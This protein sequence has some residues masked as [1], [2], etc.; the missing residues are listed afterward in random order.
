MILP[1]RQRHRIV[2]IALAIALPLVVVIAWRTRHPP[3]LMDRLPPELVEKE[4]EP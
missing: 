4:G 1:L 3:A 2:W